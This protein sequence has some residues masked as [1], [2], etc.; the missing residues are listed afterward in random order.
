MATA[1]FRVGFTRESRADTAYRRTLTGELPFILKLE[2]GNHLLQVILI[3]HAEF[4]DHLSAEGRQGDRYVEQ[5]LFTFLGG[6]DDL[7]D[8]ALPF[9]VGSGAIV[10]VIGRIGWESRQ[11]QCQSQ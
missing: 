3:G 1:R 6:H 4:F 9:V 10:V 5:V 2:A 8:I 7:F 11:G